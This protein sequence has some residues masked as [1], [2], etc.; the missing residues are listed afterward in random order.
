LRSAQRR[1]VR[2]QRAAEMA[3]SKMNDEHKSDWMGIG[4]NLEELV[5]HLGTK[6][7]KAVLLRFYE[8]RSF[9]EVGQAL[10]VSEEAARKR[11]QRAIER[12]RDALG[13]R[14]VTV[15]SAALPAMMTAH[16][17]SPASAA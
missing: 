3:N 11:V 5:A 13:R 9:P 7:R 12:L 1:R 10:G 16:I 15:T 17:S 2:E 6:D 4:A 8:G 14:G